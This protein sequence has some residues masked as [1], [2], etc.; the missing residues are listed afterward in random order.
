MSSPL[1]TISHDNPISVAAEMMSSKKIRKL[2]VTE[3]NK[4]IGIITSTDLVNHLVK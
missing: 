1:I 3:D 4:I 2:A